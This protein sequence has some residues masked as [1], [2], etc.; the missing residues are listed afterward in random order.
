MILMYNCLLLTFVKTNAT[1]GIE[2]IKN[3]CYISLLFSM[4]ESKE[5]KYDSTDE[6]V[7]N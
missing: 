6:S 4:I 7:I 3:V 1:R 5:I 2:N